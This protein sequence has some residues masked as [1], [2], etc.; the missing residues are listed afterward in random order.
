MKNIKLFVSEN[1]QLLEVKISV[2]LNRRVS[3]MI[4]R[5]SVMMLHVSRHVGLYSLSD[6]S[7]SQLHSS[8]FVDRLRIRS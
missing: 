4:R 3:V 8:Q 5:V 2:Y 7:V 6:A 1:F